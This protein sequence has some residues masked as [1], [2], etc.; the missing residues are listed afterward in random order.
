M[1]PGLPTFRNRSFQDQLEFCVKTQCDLCGARFGSLKKS[2]L[3][4]NFY[5]VKKVMDHCHL[6]SGTNSY[7][8]LTRFILCSGCNL[9]LRLSLLNKRLPYVIYSHNA[10]NYDFIH[11]F[12]MCTSLA[13]YEFEQIDRHGEIVKTKL[14]RKSPKIL[15]KNSE[16]LISLKILL[17]CDRISTCDRCSLTKLEKETYRNENGRLPACP[18]DRWLQF[19][20][21]FSHVNFSLNQMIEDL[22][23]VSEI[24]KISMKDSF[25]TSYNYL[26]NECGYNYDQF[27]LCIKSK[28]CMPFEK[29]SSL[30][31][32]LDMR[33]IPPRDHFSSLLRDQES[34][35]ESDYDALKRV[36]NELHIENMYELFHIYLCL[37]TTMLADTLKFYFE[38]IFEITGLYAYHFLTIRLIL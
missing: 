9:N 33:Q 2:P 12:K 11:L 25:S 28:L 1:D 21:S 23:K 35:N 32:L 20:D 16:T 8:K 37:D 7:G 27:I 4:G 30:K 38:R 31:Y 13:N 19:Q 6:Q 36:W 29:V 15:F 18:M 34:I 5:T 17:S 10:K 3:T 22:N 24:E 26:I 14:F